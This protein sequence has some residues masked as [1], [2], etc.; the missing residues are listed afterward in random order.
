MKYLD[1]S[2]RVFRIERIIAKIPVGPNNA[3]FE[4]KALEDALKQV[5]REA[6]STK[7]ENES[8]AD[9]DE[10][11]CPVF[12]AATNAFAA[13]G[14]LKLFRSYGDDKDSTPI[15][16]A[17]RATTA[18]PI[19]FPPARVDKPL[20]PRRYVDGGVMANNP[21]WEAV[22]EGKKYF[23]TRKC[24]IV[25]VGTGIQKPVN[26]IGKN[27]MATTA[28][29]SKMHEPES[30]QNPQTNDEVEQPDSNQSSNSFSGGVKYLYAQAR[31]KISKTITAATT[32]MEP[33]TDKASQ[34]TRM[35][36]G[37]RAAQHILEAL[38]TLTSNCEDIQ[39]KVEDE[40]ISEDDESSR[41][42]YF[43]FNVQRGMDEIGLEEWRMS[44]AMA[45]LT[46]SYLDEPTKVKK[47]LKECAKGLESPSSV[48]ST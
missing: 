27:V 31:T 34:L 8:M 24:F 33:L 43:R 13:D 1:F 45:G 37:A 6:H 17:A 7:S 18:A 9:Y 42:S 40:A 26:F 38:I 47:A 14:P 36:G 19:F 48:Q 39:R 25:S 3:Y 29:Q 5:I 15:W 32:S 35:Y 20:P 28:T 2:V 30:P 46:D 12:V 41:F 21:A 16:Q 22:I 11:S 44:E 10:P 23:K 4:P